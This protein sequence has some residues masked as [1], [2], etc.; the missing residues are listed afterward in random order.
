MNR[1]VQLPGKVVVLAQPQTIAGLDELGDALQL[2]E[3]GLND[4]PEA[5]KIADAD[6]VVIEVDPDQPS[7]IDRVGQ[8]NVISPNTPIIAGVD[9]LDIRSTRA[10][11]KRGVIDVLSIP[12]TIDDLLGALADVNLDSIRSSAEQVKLAP[13]ISCI[14]CAGGVGTT[15]IATHLAGSV[16]HDQYPTTLLDLNLQQG[17][18]T[19]FLG[20]RHRFSLQDLIEAKS[21]LDS[22]L[23]NSVVAHRE[24]MPSVLAAPTDILPIEAMSF[25]QLSAILKMARES[26]DLVVADM[27]VS[28]TNWALSTLFASDKIVLV[29]N[30]SVHALRKL[31]RQIDFFV[32]MG[33]DREAI[34]VVFNKVHKG[35]FRTLKIDDAADALRHPVLA[36]LPEEQAIIGQAQD[37]GELVWSQNKRSKFGKSMNELAD[38]LF[39][40]TDDGE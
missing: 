36:T 40:E 32:A 28:M 24:D 26:S 23:F 30:L 6:I 39:D 1:A 13:L 14:G 3:C 21:R 7:S 12:F 18:A 20:Y 11:M 29:G 35:M 5:S 37:Q 2:V 16:A 4:L 34:N 9:A 15:T 8:V 27:P 31:K 19:S 38:L 33:I 17:D 25:E 22:E 10:L